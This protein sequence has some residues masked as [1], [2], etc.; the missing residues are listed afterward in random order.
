MF[1][2]FLPTI[3]VIGVLVLFTGL[4]IGMYFEQMENDKCIEMLS[5]NYDRVMIKAFCKATSFSPCDILKSEQAKKHYEKYVNG[6]ITPLVT[7]MINKTN[8][9]QAKSEGQAV[10]M[11]TGI[12][13]GMSI[14]SGIK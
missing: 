7:S 5:T 10:G 11:A 1:D 6:E 14:N 13:V 4:A 9:D 8:Q 2:D 3:I 12:A